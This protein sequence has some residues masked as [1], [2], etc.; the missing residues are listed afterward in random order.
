VLSYYKLWKLQVN[1]DKTV[2]KI[3]T[4]SYNMIKLFRNPRHSIALNNTSIA[5]SETM[6][7][8]GLNLD[9]RLNFGAHTT[10]QLNKTNKAILTL[11]CLC[12]KQS[13][14]NKGLNCILIKLYLRPILSYA[15][16]VILNGNKSCIKKMQT[17]QNKCLR[18]ALSLP[19]YAPADDLHRLVNIPTVEEF[20]NSC[21]E[22]FY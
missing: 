17:M 1:V 18:M 13:E 2:A 10:I 11:F 6:L 22:K 3:F 7:Y 20:F 21:A 16:M 4:K 8:L 15:P 5:W 12:C 19:R 9:T 14:L